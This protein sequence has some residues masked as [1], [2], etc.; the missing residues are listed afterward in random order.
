MDSLASATLTVGNPADNESVGNPVEVEVT[1]FDLA[2]TLDSYQ[3]DVKFTPS[4]LHAVATSSG[5]GSIDNAGGSISGIARGNVGLKSGGTLLKLSF[6]AIAPGTCFLSI[7]TPSVRLLDSNGNEIP[8]M[9]VG[10][11]VSVDRPRP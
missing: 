8:F 6:K 5:T 1:L 9:T 3:F 2:T 11:R 7:P 4:V 10:G